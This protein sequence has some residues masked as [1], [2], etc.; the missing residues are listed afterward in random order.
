MCVSQ[1]KTKK[2]IFR[3]HYDEMGGRLRDNC[4]FKVHSDLTAGSRQYVEQ[5]TLW[6]LPPVSLPLTTCGSDI[7]QINCIPHWDQS[8]CWILMA[9]LPIKLI[10]SWI[11]G[12]ENNRCK[13]RWKEIWIMYCRLLMSFWLI[14]LIWLGCLWGS[15]CCL[16]QF[17]SSRPQVAQS[18]NL[19]KLCL[20]HKATWYTQSDILVKVIN[21]PRSW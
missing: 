21:H 7:I 17:I 12:D 3:K 11:W 16:E 10:E 20:S 18:H 5:P 19:T 1:V 8:F 4:P 14:F 6:I 9:T 13:D 2:K 15:I